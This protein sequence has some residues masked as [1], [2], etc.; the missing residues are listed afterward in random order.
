MVKSDN[1]NT[2][3]SALLDGVFET[4]LWT[5][6]LDELRKRTHADYASLVFRPPGM[7]SNRVFHLFSGEQFPPLIEKLYRDSFFEKD[8]TPYHQMREGQVYTLQ[9]LLRQDNPDHQAYFRD[10]LAPSGMNE[11]RMI[12][13]VEPS[14]VNAWLNITRRDKNFTVHEDALL[15]EIAPYLQKVLRNFVAYERQRLDALLAGGAIRS[16]NF[17]WITLDATGRVLETDTQG[18]CFLT[19]SGTL[20][21]AA[22]GL[23]TTDLPKLDREIADSIKALA[24]NPGARP[25]AL[26]INRDPWLDMLLVPANRRLISAQSVPT[27]VAYVHGE[28]LLSADR[29]EQ[30]AEMFDL[31]PSEARLALA[32]SRGMSIA[33]AA[34]DLG[35]TLGSARTY[36]KKIYSKLGARGQ[37][38]LVRFIHRSV[39]GIA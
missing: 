10:V 7:P 37:A 39:L 4:P 11:L 30:L 12:R 15:I 34:V 29:C 2:L 28:S 6:F 3:L 26:I 16:L 24:S 18:R 13:I 8:P 36:S 5:S 20:R 31:L 38:D 32:L 9:E 17:G 35:L 14:G 1:G 19:E 21:E 33:E 27:I 25:R 22:N 23:L